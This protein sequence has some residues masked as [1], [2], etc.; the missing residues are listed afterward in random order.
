[1]SVRAKGMGAGIPA[2]ALVPLIR[3]EE[4]LMG[5]KVIID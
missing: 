4:K 2:E 3:E 5:R 1:M